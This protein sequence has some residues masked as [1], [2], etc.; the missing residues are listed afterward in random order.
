MSGIIMYIM[1][2]SG[3]GKTTIG[4]MIAEKFNCSFYDGD[5]FHPVANV[6]KMT[7][8]KP[9]TDE[10][11]YGWLVNINTFVKKK[12]ERENVV[13]ACSALKASYREI[14]I[15]GIP[16]DCFQW[17]WLKCDYTTIY[18]RMQSREHFM[19]PSLLRSQ[20]DLLEIP[21][22]C[23]IVDTSESLGGIKQQL[24]QFLLK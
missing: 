6:Q 9:L 17:V 20:F 1:G 13:F 4:K 19:P 21:E 5:H 7:S 14:L 2:V 24:D 15:S 11:R 8:G 16:R 23:W 10:D 18:Q 3:S 12:I 22:N